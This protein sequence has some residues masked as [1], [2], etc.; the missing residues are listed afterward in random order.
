MADRLANPPAGGPTRLALRFISGKYQGGEYPL[1]EGRQI[2]I[3][4]SSD[5]DMVLVE[6]MVSRRHAQISMNGGVISIEDLGS[7]N[8]TFVNGE[9]IQR[10][11]L[12]EGD[13]VLVGTSILKVVS[14]PLEDV[15]TEG[16]GA[17]RR[18]AA[19]MQ[20]RT[21]VGEAPRMTGN[22]EEIPLPDLLQ[23]FGTSK[24]NGVLVIRTETLTGRIYLS[25][26]LV[27]HAMIE[28]MPQLS[29]AK[30][31]YRMLA[32]QSGVFELEPPAAEEPPNPWNTSVQSLLMEGF[33]QQDELNRLLD[34]LPPLENRLQLRTPL[35]APL[36][37]LEPSHL[38]VLQLALNSS[39]IAAL[40]DRTA[41]TDLE[42]AEIIKALIKRGYLSAV[43]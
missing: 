18:P 22:I 27:A 41:V 42:T 34:D 2:V 15:R 12:R 1:E 6:E 25:T 43:P 20:Q 14:V 33:R 26:G 35:E 40:F 5:L 17:A 39:S 32:W 3:G 29:A 37:E 11:T 19:T 7:T 16:S 24:K 28:G 38:D 30:A 23:L 10:A 36:H 13:R 8:G 31:A 9:K 4:R 21:M